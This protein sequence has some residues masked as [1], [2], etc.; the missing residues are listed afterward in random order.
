MAKRVV[1]HTFTGGT[2]M[3]DAYDSSKTVLG[4]LIRQQTGALPTDKFAGPT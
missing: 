4:D 1:E 2:V 3:Y